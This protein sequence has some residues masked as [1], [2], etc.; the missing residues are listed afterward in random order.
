MSRVLHAAKTEEM[1]KKEKVEKRGL[2][3]ESPACT[4]DFMH[5]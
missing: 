1:G 5:V 3:M 4:K 2:P